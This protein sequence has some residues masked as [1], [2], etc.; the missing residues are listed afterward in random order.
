MQ[1]ERPATIRKPLPLT[2][3]VDIVF[4]LLMFFMLTSN[5]T[6]FGNLGLG[7]T[8][9]SQRQVPQGLPQ[10]TA[11]PALIVNVEAHGALRVNG[12]MVN[13][14][15]LKAVLDDFA[16]KDISSAIIR[17]G[18]GASVQDLVTALEIAQ[19]SKLQNIKVAD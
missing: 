10:K 5:F 8:A 13:P 1:L 12:R 14:D 19:N 15:Q 17:S 3:L 16:A 11:P 2:P 7:L 9:V 18:P 4:L 6:K